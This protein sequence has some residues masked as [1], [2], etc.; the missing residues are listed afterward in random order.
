MVNDI[1]SFQILVLENYVNDIKINSN[2][3]LDCGFFD[4]NNLQV[5]QFDH[6]DINTKEHFTFNKC[7]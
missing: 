7:W 2:G 6:I 5:L 3:C 1:K 4:I